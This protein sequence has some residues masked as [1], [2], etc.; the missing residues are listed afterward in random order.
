MKRERVGG[1]QCG[2]GERGWGPVK[3]CCSTS[4]ASP[5]QRQEGRVVKRIGTQGEKKADMKIAAGRLL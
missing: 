1:D 5:S 2:R 4:V 3:T